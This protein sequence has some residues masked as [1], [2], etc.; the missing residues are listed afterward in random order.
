MRKTLKISFKKIELKN[1][2]NV[3]VNI[4]KKRKIKT[5]I[6]FKAKKNVIKKNL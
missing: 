5:A 1:S 3:K 2:E 6:K 4:I